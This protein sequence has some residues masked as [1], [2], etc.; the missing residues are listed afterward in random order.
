MNAP[1]RRTFL[2]RAFAVLGVGVAV[3]ARPR[4]AR[5]ST[6]PYVGEIMPFAGNFAPQGWLPCNGQLLPIAN[7]DTLFNLI[8]TTYGG[9]G[10][11]TFALPDL[12]GRAPM[13]AGQGLGLTTRV[14]GQ[15]GGEEAVSLLV[16]Q[17]PVHSHSALAA[18]ANGSSPVPG[19]RLPARN[20]AGALH[21]A[22]T[23]PGVPMAPDAIGAGGGNQPHP[24]MQPFLAITYCIAVDGVWPSPS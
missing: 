19:T 12:R 23:S 4:V 8:G 1:G 21:Y 10:Q 7:Y 5:A 15:Q 11:F 24:N 18:S 6:T 13:H 22:A 2:R 16:H 20:S 3:V 9:D 14:V 17:A